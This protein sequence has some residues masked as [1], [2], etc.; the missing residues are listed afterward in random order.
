MAVYKPGEQL[1]NLVQKYAD[2]L[3][4][5]QP[6]VHLL[7]FHD[8]ICFVAIPVYWQKKRDV[9]LSAA[10]DVPC[11]DGDGGTIYFPKFDR[12]AQFVD[13]LNPH[14]CRRANSIQR[15]ASQRLPGYDFERTGR[16]GKNRWSGADPD[17]Y[18]NIAAADY[19]DPGDCGADQLYAAYL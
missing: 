10:A 12:A 6:V 13:R 2:R 15:L 8:S 9:R 7:Y 3:D 16:R 14:L 11:D 17:F 19:S 4:G 1:C 5:Q 18:S